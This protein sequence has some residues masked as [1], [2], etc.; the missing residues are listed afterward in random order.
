MGEDEIQT[1][2]VEIFDRKLTIRSRAAREH[3]HRV[4]REVDARMREAARGAAAGTDPLRLAMLAAM[5]LAD[6]VFQL[7]A[8]REVFLEELAARTERLSAILSH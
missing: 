5:E 4:A 6:Q 2:T 8:D 3:T 1:L 7:Q